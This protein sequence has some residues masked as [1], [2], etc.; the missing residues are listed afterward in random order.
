MAGKAQSQGG[1]PDS[2][3][4]LGASLPAA[5]CRP[6]GGETNRLRHLNKREDL[7]PCPTQRPADQDVCPDAAEEDFPEGSLDAVCGSF[8]EGFEGRRGDR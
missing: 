5:A 6:G 2:G 1:K 3:T 8:G 4:P 7:A